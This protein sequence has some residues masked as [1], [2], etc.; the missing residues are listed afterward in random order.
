MLGR[1]APFRAPRVVFL[2][3]RALAL[4]CSGRCDVPPIVIGSCTSSMMPVLGGLLDHAA[5]VPHM[6]WP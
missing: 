5:V 4:S 1:I 2:A 3:A 6:Y